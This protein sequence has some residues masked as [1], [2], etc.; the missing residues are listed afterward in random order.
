MALNMSVNSVELSTLR[1][2]T[3]VSQKEPSAEYKW[4]DI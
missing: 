2:L 4:S 3:E 1:R